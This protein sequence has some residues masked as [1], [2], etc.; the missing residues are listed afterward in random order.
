MT[1]KALFKCEWE[2]GNISFFL[3]YTEE[4]AILHFEEEVGPVDPT[5]VSVTDSFSVHFIVPPEE[6][7]GPGPGETLN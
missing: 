7:G 6:G 3:A 5:W 1:Y 4:E 2:N